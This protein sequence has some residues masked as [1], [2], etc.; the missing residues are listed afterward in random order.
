M[1]A[2]GKSEFVNRAVGRAGRPGLEHKTTPRPPILRPAAQ[3]P[4]PTA[5]RWPT[6][7]WA[8]CAA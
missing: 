7:R 3:A 1:V 6:P 2:E 8:S 4:A 5:A